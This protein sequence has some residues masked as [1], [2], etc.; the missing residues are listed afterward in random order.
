M[1]P[2]SLRAFFLAVAT[3]LIGLGSANAAFLGEEVTVS[4]TVHTTGATDQIVWSNEVQSIGFLVEYAGDSVPDAAPAPLLWN[5]DFDPETCCFTLSVEDVNQ[6]GPTSVDPLLL[7]IKF[8]TTDLSGGVFLSGANTFGFLPGDISVVGQTVTISVG[9]D[10]LA[11]LDKGGALVSR[12]CIAVIPEASSIAMLAMAG[13]TVA[14]G[15]FLRRRR[16]IG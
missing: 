2:R 11:N 8:A 5:L 7:T 13:V 16:R 1:I 12:F 10:S 4:M 6:I 15:A 9:A 14:G 3:T